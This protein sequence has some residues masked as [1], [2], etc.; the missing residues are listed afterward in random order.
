[1]LVVGAGCGKKG[2]PLAPFIRIPAAVEQIEA[3]AFGRDVYVTLTIP[4]INIDMSKPANVG[5]VDVYGYTGR[6]APPRTRWVDAGDLI[7]SVPV[8]PVPLEG[9]A[10][11]KPAPRPGAVPTAAPQGTQITI[12]DRLEPAELE[13]GRIVVDAARRALPPVGT[14]AAAPAE[15]PPLK[16]FYVAFAYTPRGRPGPPGTAAEIVLF[17]PPE[18]PAA[19]DVS[20][21]ALGVSLSWPPSGGLLG[22]L[23]DRALPDE[24]A[25]FLPDEPETPA[26][27]PAAPAAPAGPTHYI[28][29]REIEADP[30]ASLSSIS[31]RVRWLAQPPMPLTPVPLPAL[32][33]TDRAIA[34]GRHRCYTVRAVRG[35]TTISDPSPPACVTPF[36]VFPPAAPRAL[37]AVAS[38]GAINLIWEPNVEPDLGG[39]VVLRGEAG[40]A[41][42]QPLTP[43]PI[44]EANY[45]DMAVKPG[46]R[47][48]YAVM[49]LDNRLPMGNWS[50]PSTPV[51]ETAR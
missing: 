47:Y 1:M 24:E 12:H 2:P 16:R 48:V 28:V 7:A 44:V 5:Q 33:Y 19:V 11:P 43:A 21:S 46:T 3:R 14:P 8:A 23:F 39:Y 29:Y 6:A 13:Q 45:R 22:F 36:D 20:Y 4:A 15:P 51:E 30:L 50:E 31:P 32:T 37:A 27:A 9:E 10:E 17:P 41:T 26:A 38:E 25:P 34:F 42:L 35:G 40:D 49:A 18:A